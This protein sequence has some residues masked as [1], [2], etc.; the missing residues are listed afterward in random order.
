MPPCDTVLKS[1]GFPSHTGSLHQPHLAPAWMHFPQYS[2]LAA[3]HSFP[4]GSKTKKREGKKEAALEGAGLQHSPCKGSSMLSPSCLHISSSGTFCG[5][6]VIGDR[7]GIF[8]F[9]HYP[10]CCVALGGI[11]CPLLLTILGVHSRAQSHGCP[12]PLFPAATHSC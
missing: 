8:H 2:A 10:R 3:M 6:M 11:F 5:L 4:S 1:H 9:S 7:T 12:P